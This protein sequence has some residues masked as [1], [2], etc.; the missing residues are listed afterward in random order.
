MKL[1]NAI[2]DFLEYIE[3]EKNRS[4]RTITNYKFYL[5]RFANWFGN[6]DVHLISADDIR[7]FRLWL[8]RFKTQEDEALQKNTQNYHLIA[9]RAF[10]KY[11]SKQDVKTL[12]PEK[13]ELMKMPEREVNF[14][15]KDEMGKLLNAPVQSGT[16]NRLQVLRD[17]AI[18]ETL[19]STG[20]R[21]SELINIK[22]E[23]VNVKLSE[24][25]VAGKGG[26]RRVVFLSDKA[27]DVLKEYLNAR[28]D[29][30]PYLFTSCDKA[31]EKRARENN[32]ADTKPLNAR[33]IQRTINKY[34]RAAGI[35][36]KI[37]PHTLRHS[38]ATD[39]LQNG[40][41]LRSVQALLGHSSITTTQIYTHITD[42][43]LREVHKKFHS[44]K[45]V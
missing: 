16:K 44:A 11:L 22:K 43:G 37:T 9:L 8:N 6:K 19:F 34:G 24:F 4:P 7:K 27:R 39:L 3:I 20:L 17:R 25:S 21:V 26:K 41:D 13:I 2:N 35:I 18:L 33:S 14:L 36:K 23:D 45:N 5:G 32:D 10:L 31:R 28:Q 30:S 1:R 29:M 12:A 42:L 40:A 15:N 38:F